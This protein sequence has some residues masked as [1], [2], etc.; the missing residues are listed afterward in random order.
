ML[1]MQ[2]NESF[3][4]VSKS[5]RRV[6]CYFYLGNGM[7][8]NMLDKLKKT[9]VR[10]KVSFNESKDQWLNEKVQPLI[11]NIKIECDYMH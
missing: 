8:P 5:C 1:R 10:N 9:C 2:K 7:S 4:L 11:W 6:G 3:I